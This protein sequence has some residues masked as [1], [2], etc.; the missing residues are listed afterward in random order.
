MRLFLVG[1]LVATTLS[2][3]GCGASTYGGLSRE[4]AR[5]KAMEIT[6]DLGAVVPHGRFKLL[7]IQRA[8]LK[9][10]QH[11]W[12]AKFYFVTPA[13]ENVSPFTPAHPPPLFCVYVWR[14]GSTVR[15]DGSGGFFGC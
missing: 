4:E 6:G 15:T 2:A 13:D 5:T 12:K 8:A 3:T 9:G 7:T 14:T 11:A 1:L 10:G